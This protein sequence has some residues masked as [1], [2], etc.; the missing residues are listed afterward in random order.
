[1]II[2]YLLSSKSKNELQNLK[3]FS[4]TPKVY[5][6]AFFDLT[7]GSK[8]EEY[9]ANGV[10]EQVRDFISSDANSFVK[11]RVDEAH[12]RSPTKENTGFFGDGARHSCALSRSR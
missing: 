11:N 5:Y 10:Y 7:M 6:D 1:M 4:L 12:E 2:P 8:R 3:S 9:I